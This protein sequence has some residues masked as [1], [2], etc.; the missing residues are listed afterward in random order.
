MLTVSFL[1]QTLEFCAIAVSRKLVELLYWF[2]CP[3]NPSPPQKKIE[4]YSTQKFLF[5]QTDNKVISFVGN[6][7]KAGNLKGLPL[8][9]VKH[10]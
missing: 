2:G 6:L 8:S 9:Q 7:S 10:G 1:T 4:Q 3:K 5:Y